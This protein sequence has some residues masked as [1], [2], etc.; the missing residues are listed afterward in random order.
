MQ[1]PSFVGRV[2][3]ILGS[4]SLLC[5]VTLGAMSYHDH[6]SGAWFAGLGDSIAWTMIPTFAV[7]GAGGIIYAINSA[8]APQDSYGSLG[9]R[10]TPKDKDNEI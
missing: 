5:A 1:G 7:L 10:D 3:G 6:H 8:R 9:L 4:I 2:L